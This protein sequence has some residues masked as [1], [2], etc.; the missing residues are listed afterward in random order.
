[1]NDRADELLS[2]MFIAVE[3]NNL[4]ALK[5][6]LDEGGDPNEV[7]YSDGYTPLGYAVE[8]GGDQVLKLMLER[9][10]NPDG[11]GILVTTLEAAENGRLEI[12][13]ILLEAGADPNRMDEDGESAVAWAQRNK[14][15]EVLK[16]IETCRR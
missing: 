11:G 15:A 5:E 12:L 1:M 2:K 3:Q 16:V 4:P 6:L 13:K 10:A 8:L 9:G 7:C 14:A